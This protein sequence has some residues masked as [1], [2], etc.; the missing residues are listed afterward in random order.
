M[1]DLTNLPRMIMPAA[2][3]DLFQEAMSELSP[4]ADATDDRVAAFVNGPGGGDWHMGVT[5]GAFDLAEGTTDSPLVAVSV[6][7][8]DWREFVAGR[9]RDVIR[10]H[11]DASAL[12]PSALAKLQGSGERAERL[13]TFTGDIQC[14]IEDADEDA[15][16]VVTVTLGGQ[17]PNISAPTTTIRVDLAY[18]GR[19]ASRS[20]NVQNAFFAG[21]IRIEGDMNL[22][23]GLMT[24]MM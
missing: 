5:D 11:A 4:P 7:V 16:Y 22:A 21:K 10:D 13:R 17:A 23:M 6:T 20:E 12:D 14:I 9:V 8:A 3:A 2:F 1:A 24:A 18:L 19:L 15:E